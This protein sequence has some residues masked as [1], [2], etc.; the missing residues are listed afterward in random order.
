MVGIKLI[1]MLEQLQKIGVL[2]MEQS[3]IQGVNQ[4]ERLLC[5]FGGIVDG[6]GCITI[7][8]HRLH[9]QT[10]RETLLFAPVFIIA[11][12]NKQLI[13][14]CCEILRQIGIPFHVQFQSSD[15][16]K[17]WKSSNGRKRKDRWYITIVGLKRVSR[18]LNAFGQYIITKKAEMRLVKEFCDRRLNAE[19]VKLNK[20]N[21]GRAQYNE[22]DFEI[23]EE[24]ARIHNRNPQRLYD[25]IREYKLRN[26]IQSEHPGTPG[27]ATEMIA[28]PQGS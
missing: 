26:K 10:K 1:C 14:M 13:D 7:N 24:V 4:Q 20:G 19:F 25:E 12:T 6:E 17:K 11:N 18:A 3:P 21:Y 16:A 2:T 27:E 9:K 28:R 23:I 5:W 15:Q 8:H 22:R